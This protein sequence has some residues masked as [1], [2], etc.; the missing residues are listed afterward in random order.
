MEPVVYTLKTPITVDGREITRVEIQPPKGKHLRTVSAS[1]NMGELLKI[2][3]AV[4]GE[5]PRVFDEMS[6]ADCIDIVGII[7]SFLEGGR[8]TGASISQ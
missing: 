3:S 1:P 8:E 4:T 7:G 5:L 2:A 6:A